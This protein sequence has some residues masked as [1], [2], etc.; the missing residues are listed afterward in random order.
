MV[1]EDPLTAVAIG[2]GKFIEFASTETKKS[3]NSM[4]DKSIFTAITDYEQTE[5]VSCPSRTRDLSIRRRYKNMATVSGYVEKIKYRNEENGYSILSVNS[6]GLD[7]VLVGTFPY[8][9]EGDFIEASGRDVE[10]PIYGDQI[11]VESL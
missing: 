9:S 7:Y 4:Q 5:G 10:H 8:I 6:D 1:A 3:R 2:T 11:Q